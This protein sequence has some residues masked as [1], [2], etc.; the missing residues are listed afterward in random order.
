MNFNISFNRLNAFKENKFTSDSLIQ[1]YVLI[2]SHTRM[3][4]KEDV[5][6]C[7]KKKRKEVMLLCNLGRRKV[8]FVFNRAGRCK[9]E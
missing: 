7:R 9:G 2:S 6:I 1:E 8:E 5:V 4:A 3:H